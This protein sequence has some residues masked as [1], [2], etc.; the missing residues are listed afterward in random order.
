M[1]KRNNKKL[2]SIKQLR[3]YIF[4]RDGPRGHREWSYSR[5]FWPPYFLIANERASSKISKSNI[6]AHSSLSFKSYEANTK[7]VCRKEKLTCANQYLIIF[8]A[9]AHQ[10]FSSNISFNRANSSLQNCMYMTISWAFII[11]RS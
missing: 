1:K 4:L 2:L 3:K 8:S 10:N 9:V 7:W 11:E 6:L 5:K